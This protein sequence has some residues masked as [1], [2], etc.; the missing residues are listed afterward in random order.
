VVCVSTV[1]SC[2]LIYDSHGAEIYQWLSLHL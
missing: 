1:M 2:K